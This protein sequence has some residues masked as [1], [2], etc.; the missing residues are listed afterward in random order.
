MKITA[1]EA[2][3]HKPGLYRVSIDEKPIGYVSSNDVLSL[4]L[5]PSQDI[6]VTIYKELLKQVKYSTF[7][8]KALNYADK[9]LRSKAEVIR[10]LKLKGCDSLVAE[11]IVK[12]L[13]SSGIIDEKKLAQAY[14][15]DIAS[16]KPT[17]KKDLTLKLKQK[18]IDE[19]LI[20]A[21]IGNSEF[22]EG[23]A[24]DKLIAQKSHLSSYA[25]NQPRFFRYLMSKGFSYEDIAK[26]IGK[27]KLNRGSGSGDS[28]AFK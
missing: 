27:P 1:L 7:Y 12:Q 17:S 2:M 28:A 6:D 25:N 22:D 10:Y 23:I 26:R 3:P 8:S 9:R 14:V 21:T 24:L 15:H 20:N 18:K 13:S 11:E 4:K 19:G 5:V 16:F